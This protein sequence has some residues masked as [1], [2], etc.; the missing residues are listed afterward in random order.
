MNRRQR[1]SEWRDRFRRPQ[2]PRPNVSLCIDELRLEGVPSGDR[3]R[4]ADGL[5][6][7]L[8][9]LLGVHGVPEAWVARRAMDR[10]GGPELT[11]NP[12]TRPQVLGEKLAGAVLNSKPSE[13][14]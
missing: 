10:V 2:P 11:L 6:E 14:R 8:R 9:T 7:E 1:R 4:V 5:R 12:G 3:L 13:R